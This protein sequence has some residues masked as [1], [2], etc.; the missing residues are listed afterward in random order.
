MIGAIAVI[1][2]LI[3][4]TI[5]FLVINDSDSEVDTDADTQNNGQ[6][7]TGT[8][9][10]AVTQNN[11]QEETGTETDADTETG[12]EDDGSA[13]L[14]GIG[15]DCQMTTIAAEAQARVA[16]AQTTA[17][18]DPSL[19][20]FTQL[21]ASLID[22]SDAADNKI[23]KCNHAEQ[24]LEVL[25]VSNTDADLHLMTIIQATCTIITNEGTSAEGLETYL[26]FLKSD[27]EANPPLT[28]DSR[29]Y[30]ANGPAEVQQQFQA[31]LQAESIAYTPAAT[32]EFTCDA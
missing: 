29:V 17:K 3:A 31:L 7:E 4:G 8:E 19:L 6:E 25:I 30:F 1:A 5:Y 2:L 22:E 23:L 12:T 27:F 10:D 21:Y 20:A 11:G 26:Q 18:E 28:I 32:P 15:F 14:V 13:V 9:T 24:Q 16:E